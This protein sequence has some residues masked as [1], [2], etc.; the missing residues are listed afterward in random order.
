M[1]TF[2][3]MVRESE[4]VISTSTN[5]PAEMLT[6]VVEEQD[7]ALPEME[8]LME[9]LLR[10]KL[11]PVRT[12]KVSVMP[13]PGAVSTAIMNLVVVQARGTR[14][15]TPATSGLLATALEMLR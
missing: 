3:V 1:A 15:M 13:V 2:C 9:E 8:Q 10:V 12:V 11:L 4:M 7:V 5:C 6:P 14:V